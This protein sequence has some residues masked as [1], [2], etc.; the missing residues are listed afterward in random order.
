MKKH[1]DLFFQVKALIVK[2]INLFLNIN[3]YNLYT[4]FF[5]L[6]QNLKFNQVSAMS[7]LK[8]A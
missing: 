3:T 6:H 2:Q 5:F 4:S 8:Q 1:S 7:I